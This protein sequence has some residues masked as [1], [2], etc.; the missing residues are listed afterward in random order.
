MTMEPTGG[1]VWIRASPNGVVA[2]VRYRGDSDAHELAESSQV[3][4][5]VCRKCGGESAPVSAAMIHQRKEHLLLSLW[6]AVG[7]GYREVEGAL[8]HR[9][10]HGASYFCG[11]NGQREALLSCSGVCADLNLFALDAH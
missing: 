1:L 6:N 3:L 5:D 10:R 4:F 2:D 9:V 11:C 7:V 8:Q